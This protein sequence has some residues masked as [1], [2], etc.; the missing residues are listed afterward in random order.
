MDLAA[1]QRN[2]DTFGRLDP[3]WAILTDPRHKGNRWDPERFFQTG[4]E[5]MDAFVARARRLGAPQRWRR[6][7]DFGCGVGRLTQALAA[8]VES[9]TGVDI[10]PSMIELARQYNV[11]GD[12]CRY[13]VNDSADLSGFED[14]W[15][16]IIYTG[17]VLQHIESRY[18]ENYIREMVRVLAPGGLLSFDIP[19]EHGLFAPDGAPKA[20]PRSVYKAAI[21]VLEA[22]AQ[23]LPGERAAVSL[24]VRNIGDGAWEGMELNAGNHWL[25]DDDVVQQD[26]GRTR[27]EQPWLPGERRRVSVTVT[28]PEAPGAYRL[29]FDLVHEGIAW[30]AD[31]GSR[32]AEVATGVGSAGSARTE[33][34]PEPPMA[35]PAD[36]PQ[37]EMHAVRR[38]RV[39]ELLAGSGARVL[40]TH[41]I[42]HCGPRWLAFRYDCSR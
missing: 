1:L 26:D 37:M 42:H 35:A 17:R 30:F 21:E 14:G 39:E 16:D 9:A 31:L 12:R 3:L 32:P 13:L 7:L 18:I 25:R 38:E 8:H 2:W 22:P 36:E 24:D 10:A 23:L 5:E 15:F 41:R 19:S 11:H 29:Q 27:L 33:P 6:A 4:R 28:A 20:L 40:D 34:E